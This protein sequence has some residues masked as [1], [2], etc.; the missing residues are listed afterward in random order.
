MN[1]KKMPIALTT[2]FIWQKKY[3]ERDVAA[4]ILNINNVQMNLL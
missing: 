2:D 4:I 3:A 1:L